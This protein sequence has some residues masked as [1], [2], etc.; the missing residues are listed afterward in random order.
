[1][2]L[3]EDDKKEIIKLLLDSNT[4]ENVSIIPIVGFGGLGKTTLAQLI[5]N[6]EI[7]K[8]NFE[9]KLWICISDI[10]DLERIIKEILEQLTKCK[11]EES[12]EMLQN[13]LRENLNGKKYLLVLDDLWNEDSNKWDLLKN[14]LMGGARGS[15]IVVTTRSIKVAE[16]TGT[17]TPHALEGLA[18]EKAW[19][20]FVKMAFKGGKEPKNQGIID[21]G[22]EIV[23]KCIG[24]PLAIRTIGRLLYGKTSKIEWQS[25]LD[26]ELS[27]I[28]QQE[29]NILLTLKLS[30]DHLP[31]HLKQCFAYC[32]LFPKDHRIYVNTLIFG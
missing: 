3:G 23:R 25:F 15:S 17:T 27:K 26:N 10:F 32:R 16:I 18:E 8:N 29:N 13:Q 2:W 28:A 22:K 7:V 11:H 21:L 12:L 1:M 20:L 4:V 19:S 30:Y 6:D 5:Y 24:V 9:L 14:L 31:S